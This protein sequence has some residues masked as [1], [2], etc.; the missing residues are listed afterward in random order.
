M[1]IELKSANSVKIGKKF[2][3][4]RN[5][6][7]YS[8]DEVS[9]LLFI[10]KNYLLA[11]EKGDYSIFPSESFAKAYF[12]KYQNFLDIS[13]D[14]PGVYDLKV[15]KKH[16]K[17]STEIIFK[18]NFNLNNSIIILSA[19]LIFLFGLAI[20]YFFIKLPISNDSIIEVNETD[21]ENITL[22]VSTTTKTDKVLS[23]SDE[24]FINNSLIL[25]FTGDCWM[26]LYKNGEI[27][28]AQL[29]RNENVYERI[30]EIPFKII[31]GNADFV[32]GSYNGNDI[33]F[34]T[35]ANRLTRVSTVIFSND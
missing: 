7:S 6:N 4:K 28:E 14:F 13:Y 19:F 24:I 3:K 25:E 21:A 12:K 2:S 23:L 34:K 11:I 9:K 1:S 29:F 30:I 5:D 10:N 35:D 26:E 15:E 16:K 22:E 17:I 27:I 31:V 8:I 18:N 20:Y 33:D 32:K